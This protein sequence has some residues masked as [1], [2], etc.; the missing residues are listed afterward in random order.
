MIG[1]SLLGFAL[2]FRFIAISHELT[3]DL[4]PYANILY[5]YFKTP[6]RAIVFCVQFAAIVYGLGSLTISKLTEW[7]PI[8]LA[9]ILF[10]AVSTARYFYPI[11]VVSVW[12]DLA[13]LVALLFT[14]FKHSAM[15]AL[16]LFIATLLLIVP[17]PLL[18]QL[19]SVLR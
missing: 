11:Y 6:T 10:T 3:F 19:V 14:S 12:G 4:A 17:M 9:T 13:V 8:A 18:W 5:A 2:I 1:A 15:I 7:K 16:G